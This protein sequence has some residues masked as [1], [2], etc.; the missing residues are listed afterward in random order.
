MSFVS[1]SKSRAPCAAVNSSAAAAKSSAE[2][3]RNGPIT[4]V[5]LTPLLHVRGLTRKEL[6]STVFVL[7]RD[8]RNPAGRREVFSPFRVLT[9]RMTFR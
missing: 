5:V 7:A 9:L 3:R 1:V 8:P 4:C 6:R 2:P